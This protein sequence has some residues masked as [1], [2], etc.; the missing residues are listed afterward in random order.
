MISPK[1]PAGSGSPLLDRI[2]PVFVEHDADPREEPGLDLP[3][4]SVC[5]VGPDYYRKCGTNP[6]DWDPPACGGGGGG[7]R[8]TSVSPVGQDV[9][10]PYEFI[11]LLVNSGYVGPL[12]LAFSAAP[13]PATLTALSVDTGGITPPPPWSGPETLKATHDVKPALLPLTFTVV[14]NTI[15]ITNS[16][17]DEWGSLVTGIDQE[18]YLQLTAGLLDLDGNPLANPGDAAFWSFIADD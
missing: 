3:P 6:T 4:F 5:A 16:D 11:N 10:P 8:L 9:G 2:H 17:G 12:I 13:D 7:F 15:E 14:G 18:I 1:S